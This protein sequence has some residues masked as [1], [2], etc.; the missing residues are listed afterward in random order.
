MGGLTRFH[1]APPEAH[2]SRDRKGAVSFTY[3]ANP[4]LFFSFAFWNQFFEAGADADEPAQKQAE[5]LILR[6]VVLTEQI[7]QPGGGSQM[8]QNGGRIGGVRI[9]SAGRERPGEQMP[10]VLL[11][12]MKLAL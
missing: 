4:S 8:L 3:P 11:G 9:G 10:G 2:L 1:Q 5:R 7:Q 12:Q 6:G